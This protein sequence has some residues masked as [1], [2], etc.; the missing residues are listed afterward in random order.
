MPGPGAA[1][2]AGHGLLVFRTRSG[3]PR[4]SASVGYQLMPQF[5][6]CWKTRLIFFGVTKFRG[7][8]DSR[9]QAARREGRLLHRK[10]GLRQVG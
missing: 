3:L 6:L 8:E 10:W 2:P 7:G 4:I 1:A 5:E 9:R